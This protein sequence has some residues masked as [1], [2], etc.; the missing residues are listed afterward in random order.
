MYRDSSLKG[1]SGRAPR[2]AAWWCRARRYGKPP[3][4]DGLL[5]FKREGDGLTRKNEGKRNR[6]HQIAYPEVAVPAARVPGLG[7]SNQAR[8]GGNGGGY[9]MR[10]EKTGEG[11]G[12]RRRD[13]FNFFTAASVPGRRGWVASSMILKEVRVRGEACCSKKKIQVRGCKRREF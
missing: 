13:V 11:E 12:F 2:Q 9:H 4:S 10:G 6:V 7:E 5:V 1:S 3:K 8:G